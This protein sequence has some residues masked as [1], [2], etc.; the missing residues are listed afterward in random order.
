MIQMD[1]VSRQW[2]TLIAIPKSTLLGFE[3][4]AQKLGAMFGSHIIFMEAD[5]LI[6]LG[7]VPNMG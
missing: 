3:P 5:C 7:P 1:S 4:Q 2:V 6:W